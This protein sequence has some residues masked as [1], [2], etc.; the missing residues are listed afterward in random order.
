[1][2]WVIF[3]SSLWLLGCWGVVGATL[4]WVGTGAR[5][6]AVMTAAAILLLWPIARLSWMPPLDER[7]FSS[8]SRLRPALEACALIVLIQFVLWPLGLLGNWPPVANAMVT[9]V[10]LGWAL[11]AAALL[12]LG[13]RGGGMRRSGLAALLCAVV[14]VLPVAHGLI[15]A[16]W[17]ER[18]AELAALPA[19]WGLL[20]ADAVWSTSTITAGWSAALGGWAIVVVL[21]VV[22]W[23]GKP[24]EKVGA[25]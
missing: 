17:A 23:A 22:D 1:M 16:P 15:A 24:R 19:I 21:G 5:V 18:V 13:Q 10:L 12:R 11:F 8:D 2:R 7:R 3:W 20:K 25:G 9:A 4:G 6:M 14:L